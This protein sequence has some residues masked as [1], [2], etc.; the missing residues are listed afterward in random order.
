MLRLL[1]RP[2]GCRMLRSASQP[3]PELAPLLQL[4]CGRLACGRP[5]G[6]RVG[7]PGALF[8]R[9]LAPK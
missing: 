3:P 7:W 5:P 8:N 6:A 4:A 1:V 9:G 2:G